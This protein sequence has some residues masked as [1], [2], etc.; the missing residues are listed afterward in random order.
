MFKNIIILFLI[1]VIPSATFAKYLTGEGEF[2]SV[3]TDS[4]GFVKNQLVYSAKKNILN[5][6]LNSLDLSP[7]DFWQGF[8]NKI[9]TS[10]EK[11]LESI[12]NQI[13]KQRENKDFD[14]ILDLE[15][16]KRSLILS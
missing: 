15:T 9:T 10:L 5:D 3:E 16:K 6:Y 1:S 12:E 13:S 4:P 8:E 11:R 7:Q 2:L 14:K